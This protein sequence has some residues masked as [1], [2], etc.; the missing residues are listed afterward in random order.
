MNLSTQIT[1]ELWDAVSKPYE[2]AMYKDA[3]LE[4]FHYLSN[5]LRERANVDGDGASLVGQALGGDNPRLRI[6]NFQTETE[7]NE[8]K[9]LEQTLRG[10]YL[11]IRNPRSHEQ[12]VDTQPTADAIIIFL[13]YVLRIVGQA[14]EPFT[15]D[16]WVQMVFEPNFV[17]SERYAELLV[18]DVPIKK[19]LDAIIMIYRKK[20]P[21]KANDLKLMFQSF[22]SILT[23]EQ[24]NDLLVVVSDELRTTPNDLDIQTILE[25]LPTK[26][27]PKIDEIARL[28]IENILIKSIESGKSNPN[29]TKSILG[30]LGTWAQGYIPHFTLKK[31]LLSVFLKKLRSKDFREHNYLA[32]YFMSSLADAIDQSWPSTTKTY[33]RDV[34]IHAIAEAVLIPQGS[35]PLRDEAII[36]LNFPKDW[37]EPLIASLKPL[38]ATDPELYKQLLQFKDLGLI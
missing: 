3:V 8:Q 20:T 6:N 33:Y 17:A 22:A 37:H 13:D 24:L 9:G 29:S 28:R 35:L 30:W 18:S 27:W 7:K 11:G 21:A 15:L 26:L 2:S 23:D 25:M 19:R 1:P 36:L 34:L 32:Q 31:E 38:E 12:Y 5:L 4:A 14:K 16:K 10:M